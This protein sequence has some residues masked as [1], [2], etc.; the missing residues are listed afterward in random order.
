[1]TRD[2]DNLELPQRLKGELKQ[3]FSPGGA[4]PAAAGARDQEILR[5]AMRGRAGPR[6][7][8]WVMSGA[9]A[10]AVAVVVGGVVWWQAAGAPRSAN[11][12][13]RTGDVR[14]AFYLAR[15]L[16]RGHV[17]ENRWDANND[18]RVDESDVKMVALAAV[19]VGEGGVR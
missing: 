3:L 10:A 7:R 19:K 9:V 15:E 1:M 13:V 11:N 16:K 8:R 17:V 12:Y 4:F 6:W 14:D 5:K 18:G 2:D